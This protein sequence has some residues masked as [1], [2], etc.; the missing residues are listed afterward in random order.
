M[1]KKVGGLDLVQR[2]FDFFR[3][4]WSLWLSFGRDDFSSLSSLGLLDIIF[5]DSLEEGESGIGVSDVLHSDMDFLGNL[6][7]L[8]LF[9]DNDTNRSWVDIEDL[10]SSSMI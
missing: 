5:S 7:L 2:E 10:S 9:F 3:S 4:L 8:N 1:W 6:S